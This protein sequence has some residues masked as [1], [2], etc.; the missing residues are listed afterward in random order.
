M[1]SCAIWRLTPAAHYLRLLVWTSGFYLL[2]VGG[3]LASDRP[4]IVFIFTDDMGWKDVGYHGSE[5]RTPQIDRLAAAGVK[6]EQHYVQPVCT[7]T[8]GAFLTGRYPMRYGLQQGVVLPWSLHGLPASEQTIADALKEAGYTTAIVGKWHLGHSEKAFLPLQHGFETHYGFYLGMTDYFTHQSPSAGG[9]DWHRQEQAVRE[10]GYTTELFGREAVRIIETHDLEKPLFLY[11]AFNAP[12]TPLQAPPE[13][14]KRYADLPDASRRTYAAMVECED[15]QI[16][17]IWRALEERGMTKNT[18]VVFSSDNGGSLQH[19]ANNAPLRDGKGSLYEGGVRVPAFAVWP[20]RIKAGSIIEQPV[21]VVDWHPTVLALAGAR[22]GSTHA[23]LDGIDIWPA[24][25]RGAKL[26]ERS[27]LLNTTPNSGAIR[28]GDWKL[29][30]NGSQREGEEGEATRRQK[31]A[32]ALAADE[33]TVE[34][35][36][37][38]SDR[39]EKNDLAAEQPEK[40]RELR[41]KLEAFARQAVPP[42]NTARPI[43]FKAPAVWGEFSTDA[44]TRKTATP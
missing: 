34:L 23:A 1:N 44:S 26:P 30:L 43:G 19:A 13:Y 24:I 20:D 15:A 21:H 16:G 35:F 7:P 5:I 12:H 25:T 8:R 37:L 17:A 11:V 36:N 29:V 40:V 32:G 10:E 31:A 4:N 3:V 28:T 39:G 2:L 38:A 6:L 9:L 14:E 41:S 33:S 18:L 42:P 27:I 22:P